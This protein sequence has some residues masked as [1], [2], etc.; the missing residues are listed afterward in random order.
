MN[1]KIRVTGL[2]I[3]MISVCLL[4][5]SFNYKSYRKKYNSLEMLNSIIKSI[6]NIKTMRYDLQRNERVKGKMVYS[7][8]HVKLQTVPRKLYISITDG[9][10][11]LWIQGANSGNAL[12]NPRAFPYINVNLDPMGSLMRKGQHHTINELGMEYLAD[13]LKDGMKHSGE[14]LEKQFVVLGEEKYMNRT[15][16]KISI[17]F[18]DFSW[19][20][21]TI[22]AGENLLTI[23]GKFH[24]SEY[25]LL[26][27]N[28]QISWYNETKV[29]QVIQIPNA[30]AKLILLMI[31]KE[32][33]L[34]ISE[35]ILD[36]K[37]LFESYEYYNLQVNPTIT[38][39]EF[40]KEYKE[41]HF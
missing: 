5:T 8:S 29:G 25:M 24:L 13:I 16:Y 39:E 20:S 34:P 19:S 23:A 14:K 1:F 18:P 41:Y 38:S 6:E 26:E 4:L 30:Y 37:G 9:P 21:Y 36:D 10:E 32:Y 11:V 27:N 12:I 2:C 3:V 7:E 33:M 17:A 28:P 15:C 35:K 40:T 22:K 31:D